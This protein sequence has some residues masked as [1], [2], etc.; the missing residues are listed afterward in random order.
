MSYTAR[1]VDALESAREARERILLARIAELEADA[2][3]IAAAPDLLAACKQILRTGYAD[4]GDR[5]MLEQAIA[6]A[7]G[8]E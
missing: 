1:S 7:E 3:L 8:R 6:K 5:V 4:W 2:S